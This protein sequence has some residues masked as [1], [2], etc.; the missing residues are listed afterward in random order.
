MYQY[1]KKGSTEETSQTLGILPFWSMIQLKQ[2]QLGYQLTYRLLP[3]PLQKVFDDN[4]G[5]KSHRYPTRNK[6]TPNIQKHHCILFNKSFL[7]QSI[8]QYSLLSDCLKKE[9][10]ISRFVKQMKKHLLNSDIV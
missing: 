8:K 5:K 6:S 1:Y 2:C 3:A 10:N 9:P 7:C 4:G